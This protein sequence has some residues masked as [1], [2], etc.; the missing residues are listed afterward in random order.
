MTLHYCSVISTH[1]EQVLAY[2]HYDVLR[3]HSQ[4][5]I[6][7]TILEIMNTQLVKIKIKELDSKF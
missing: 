4:D 6:S 7:Q 3:W 5:G 1:F 2:W